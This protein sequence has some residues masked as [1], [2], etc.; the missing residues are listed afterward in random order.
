MSSISASIWNV[1]ASQSSA[2][3][4]LTFQSG[5]LARVRGTEFTLPRVKTSKWVFK[6]QN[7]GYD[8]LTIKAPNG[9][10]IVIMYA[11]TVSI[12]TTNKT[13]SG[14]LVF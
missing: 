3:R 11:E 12:Q 4:F 2:Q 10:V 9:D 6:I 8:N 5:N 13:D 7:V 1:P 14:Y